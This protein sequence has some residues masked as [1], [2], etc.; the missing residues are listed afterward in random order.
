VLLRKA[1]KAVRNENERLL[2]W[3]YPGRQTKIYALE[4]SDVI[5]SEALMTS[6]VWHDALQA[7]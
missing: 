7:E 4:H 2:G 3:I 6:V 1:L 5:C